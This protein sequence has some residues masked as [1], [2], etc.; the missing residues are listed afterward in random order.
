MPAVRSRWPIALLALVC[1]G[2][3]TWLMLRT[4]ARIPP[5]A[6]PAPVAAVEPSSTLSV[7]TA[8]DAAA[9]RAEGAE[10]ERIAMP[11]PP[12]PVLTIAG[13]V[14]RDDDRP[15]AGA[16]VLLYLYQP[17]D[18]AGEVQP[19]LAWT[20]DRGHFTFQQPTGPT[21]EW[22]G[23][24]VIWASGFQLLSLPLVLESG[25]QDGDFGT[26]RMTVSPGW[27]PQRSPNGLT[28]PD[29]FELL[30]GGR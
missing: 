23:S 28:L 15:L 6:V 30:G 16:K 19:R 8:R 4:H 11:E 2:T 5:A 21:Q 25:V 3:V 17:D 26:I 10:V 20:D 14:L 1:A 29:L 18:H 13:T 22:H 27:H 12:A 9:R 24:V 7:A